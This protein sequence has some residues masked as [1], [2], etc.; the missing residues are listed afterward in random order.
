MRVLVGAV[1]C[2]PVRSKGAVTASKCAL[3][4]PR[5]AEFGCRAVAAATVSGAKRNRAPTLQSPPIHLPMNTT[6]NTRKI[7]IIT[8]ALLAASHDFHSSRIVLARRT[9]GSGRRSPSAWANGAG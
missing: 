4:V 6:P 1:E 5:V 7:T 2:C 3:A 8:V 9:W